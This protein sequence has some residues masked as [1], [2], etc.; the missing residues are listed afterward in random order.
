[1]QVTGS[2]SAITSVDGDI[3]IE[4]TGGGS[5][6]DNRGISIENGGTIS[7][8]GEGDIKI[9]GTGSIIGGD[10]NWGVFLGNGG[11]IE[12]KHKGNITVT[13][14]GGG[15]NSSNGYH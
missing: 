11:K 6:N 13:A 14:N 3:T 8:E 9:I 1:V 4:G 5:G 10:N 15:E 2:N 12:S 7:S